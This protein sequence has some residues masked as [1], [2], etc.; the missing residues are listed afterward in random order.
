M[1]GAR[2]L[3][4]TRGEVGEVEGYIVVSGFPEVT[5]AMTIANLKDWEERDRS[6]QEIVSSIQ[7]RMTRIPGILAAPTNPPSFGQ[8]GNS[9][10][11]EFVIQTSGSSSGLLDASRAARDYN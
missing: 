2:I 1:W 7:P 8:R 9:K 4:A 11:V 3:D 10:P 6:Q 5:Q